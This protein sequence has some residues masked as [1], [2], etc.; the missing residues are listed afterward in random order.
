[1][2]P[3]VAGGCRLKPTADRK[4]WA[5]RGQQNTFGLLPGSPETGGTCPGATYGCAGCQSTPNGRKTPLCYVEKIMR[6]RKAV[7]NSLAFNTEL[8][9]QSMYTEKVLLLMR[10]FNR[11]WKTEKRRQKTDELWYRL[12]WS[13]DIPDPEYAHALREAIEAHPFINFWCYTRSFFSVPILAG[14]KNLQLYISL[15]DENKDEG[16]EVYR[17]FSD[18]ENVQVC[19]MSETCPDGFRPCPVDVGRKDLENACQECKLCLTG[20]PVWFKTRK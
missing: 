8:F 15:D 9:K 11:F 20:K 17:K 16:L 13:G 2:T 3:T 1:M 12:H 14:L 7:A 10:E 5:Y 19:W 4:T 6:G 18:Y